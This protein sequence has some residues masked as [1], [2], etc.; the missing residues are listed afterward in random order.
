[1]A[2]NFYVTFLTTYLQHTKINVIQMSFQKIISVEDFQTIRI[3]KKW[4]IR[5]KKEL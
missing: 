2:A 5:T 3:Y 4:R 1:M